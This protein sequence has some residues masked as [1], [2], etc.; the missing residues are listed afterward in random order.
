[1]AAGSCAGNVTLG[2]GACREAEAP[3]EDAVLRSSLAELGP[4][5]YC[6]RSGKGRRWL[7][8][9]LQPVRSRGR[10]R[11]RRLVVE[12]AGSSDETSGQRGGM[13]RP[14]AW[15]V[16]VLMLVHGIEQSLL[17]SAGSGSFKDVWWTK[18]SK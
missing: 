3:W 7:D 11:R 8:L 4:C 15:E 16:P 1:M 9:V 14:S 2:P 12:V 5:C 18:H 17:C 13:R 10:R 6:C